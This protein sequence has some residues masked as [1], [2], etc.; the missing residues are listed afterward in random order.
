MTGQNGSHVRACQ[1]AGEPLLLDEFDR[2]GEVGYRRQR[3]VV[4]GE[5]GPERRG[6][7]EHLGKP[8]QLWLGHLAVML[9]GHARV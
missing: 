4:H 9:A 1:Y 5:N 8:R 3:R 7:V 2:D 6:N